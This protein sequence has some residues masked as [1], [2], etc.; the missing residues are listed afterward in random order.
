MYALVALLW[1][2]AAAVHVHW[3]APVA[4]WGGYGSEA[5]QFL[6][7]FAQL[8]LPSS[9]SGDARVTASAAQH[10][11]AAS[12]AYV[13]GLP[14]A[15]RAVL[16]TALR[17]VPPPGAVCVCHSEPGAWSPASRMPARYST[18]RCPP[19]HGCGATAGRTMFETDRLPSGWLER[20]TAMDEVWLPSRWA[21]DVFAEGG[22]PREKMRVLGEAVDGDFFS[23]ASGAAALAAAAAERSRGADSLPT[24]RSGCLAGAH[25]AS[26]GCPYRF[27][28]VGKL[29]RRKNFAALLRAFFTEFCAGGS[30][31]SVEL[32]VLTS[33]YH[34]AGDV[35]E[36]LAA[37]VAA[38]A[39]GEGGGGGGGGDDDASM[40]CL[41]AAAAAALARSSALKVW[42]AV[43]QAQL[44][45]L[46][47]SV[48]AFVLPSRGEG[49]GRPHVEAM[50]MALPVIATDWSGSTEFLDETVGYPVP[51]AALAPI[52]DG[53]FA[54]HLQAEVSL[55][56]RRA[57]MRR[58][59]AAQ[60]EAAARGAR[61]RERMLQRYAPAVVAARAA[62]LAEDLAARVAARRGGARGEEL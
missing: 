41:S 8:S 15:D 59:L 62:K 48:D 24:V 51:V 32:H 18:P 56:A 23:P 60:G 9:S 11:D 19:L 17:R 50:A 1:A 31:G 47:A 26:P 44:P 28:A 25:G 33:T 29:E 46:Y 27:L 52:P 3:S 53:A 21:A 7:G 57:A 36:K 2:S 20:I 4:S 61:A 30:C 49:W 12:D 45:A 5:L 6:R 58:V 54:G 38:L 13:S 42:T 16:L 34:E 10:G 39:C 37:M 40:H 35:R 14:A 22:V 43:P 55:P